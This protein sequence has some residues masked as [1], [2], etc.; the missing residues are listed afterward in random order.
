PGHGLFL[1]VLASKE[2]SQ[3][4]DSLLLRFTILL[5]WIQLPSTANFTCQQHTF[6]PAFLPLT[7]YTSNSSSCS[8]LISSYKK[9]KRKKKIE[10]NK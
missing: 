6:S 8:L 4:T 9:K 3:D 2:A 10:K 7:T 5:H 1:R